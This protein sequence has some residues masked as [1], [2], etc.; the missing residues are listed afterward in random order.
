MTITEIRTTKRGRISVYVDG[1]Y[2]FAVEEESWQ[3]C[4]LRTGDEVDE[5]QLNDLLADSNR[6][7]AK[8]RALNML[9]SRD[10]TSG[11]L[12]ER[13]AAKTDARSAEQAV[14][15][16]QELGLVDD[17]RYAERFAQELAEIKL[18]G[19]RRIKLELQ[20]RRIP[21]DIIQDV[22][23]QLDADEE[24]ERALKLLR[25]KFGRIGGEN[26]VK[27]AFSLLERSGYGYH[28]IRAA[29]REMGSET[30]EDLF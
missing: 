25:K 27:K 28:D 11:V 26:A 19:R 2:L 13:L 1:E 15:R 14:E 6:I 24:A 30:D 29:L 17:A 10:Y 12:K 5:Q 18:F 20:K 9:S 8:R 3:M 21:A 16:M 23:E 4:S 7:K 22:M